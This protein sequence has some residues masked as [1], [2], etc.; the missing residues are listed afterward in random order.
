MN[1]EYWDP[2]T[3]DHAMRMVVGM[4]CDLVKF[5]QST[6]RHMAVINRYWDGKG[7]VL[8]YGCGIGRLTRRL[9]LTADEV[10]GAD[11]SQGMLNYAREVAR[12]GNTK[13]YLI[14][15]LPILYPDKFFDFGLCFLVLEHLNK[16]E[17]KAVV[18]EIR[19]LC[20]SY[21]LE[22]SAFGNPNNTIAKP[23]AGFPASN[24][25]W[26]QGEIPDSW[27]Q[28]NLWDDNGL[29]RWLVYRGPE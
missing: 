23:Q 8:D 25:S 15:G 22:L 2:L 10:V 7:R 26:S 24:L 20:K 27:G 1:P 13:W 6:E 4:D 19:R 28:V 16:A 5:T 17:A 18:D 14:E 9:A 21:L 12:S 29:N 3:F 11:I